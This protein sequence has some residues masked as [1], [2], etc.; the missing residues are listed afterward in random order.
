MIL[1]RGDDKLLLNF[2]TSN[3]I[4]IIESDGHAV[5]TK[6]E[7]RHTH[8]SCFNAFRVIPVAGSS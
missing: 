8:Y 2:T 4:H 3:Y 1:F 7:R 6:I 5:Q